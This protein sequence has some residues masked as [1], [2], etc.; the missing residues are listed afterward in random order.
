MLHRYN[1]Y[2][3]FS[4]APKYFKGSRLFIIV[5]TQKCYCFIASNSLNLFY[6]IVLMKY[7]SLF[8]IIICNCQSLKSQVILN[9][10][11]KSIGVNQIL[12]TYSIG[13]MV[14]IETAKSSL[15]EIYFTQGFLQP[16]DNCKVQIERLH[17]I[18]VYPNPFTDDFK[19]SF[20]LD[21]EDE[22][23]I[24]LYDVLGRLVMESKHVCKS[25]Y[26][27]LTQ[28]GSSLMSGNYLLKVELKNG[29][30]IQ[31]IKIQKN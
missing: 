11:S 5:I 10:A 6:N 28:A 19:L 2:Y 4:M 24:S 25:G 20:L 26:N 14:S 7:V 30:Q 9:S 3:F 31:Q 23:F 15:D 21:K 18:I 16:E 27:L 22:I 1:W 17:N 12:H 29:K 13:E 8:L